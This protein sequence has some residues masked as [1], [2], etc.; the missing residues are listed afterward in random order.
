MDVVATPDQTA[1]TNVRAFYRPALSRHGCP[2]R[3]LTEN[4]A[5]FWGEL[6]RALCDEFKVAKVFSMAY[7][8]EGDSYAERFMRNLNNSLAVPSG[9]DP[10]R[11]DEY[12]PGVQFGYNITEHAAMG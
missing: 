3:L 8:P 5:S 2:Q 10:K 6:V 11:W 12:V 1:P 9:E 4:E 7:Y